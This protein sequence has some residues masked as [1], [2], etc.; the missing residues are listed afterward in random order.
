[1]SGMELDPA[2]LVFASWLSVSIISVLRCSANRFQDQEV[3]AMLVVY[4]F[5]LVR[6]VCEPWCVDDLLRDMCFTNGGS[7]LEENAFSIKYF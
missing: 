3:P 4:L 2:S 5:D 7:W 1:M 6:G